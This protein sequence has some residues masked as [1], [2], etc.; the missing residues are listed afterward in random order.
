MRARLLWRGFVSLVD[1]FLVRIESGRL[2]Y[3]ECEVVTDDGTTVKTF[4]RLD[5]LL[6]AHEAGRVRF[7]SCPVCVVTPFGGGIIREEHLNALVRE[8]RR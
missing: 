5:D 2:A 7:W 4:T 6:D 1:A 3:Y 8:R